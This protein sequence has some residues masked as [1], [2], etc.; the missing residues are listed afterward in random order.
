MICD[1]PLNIWFFPLETLNLWHVCVKEGLLCH[2]VKKDNN[3]D[4]VTSEWLT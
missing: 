2:L 4:V 3:D 1:S